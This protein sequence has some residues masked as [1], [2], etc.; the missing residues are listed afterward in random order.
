MVPPRQTDLHA[1]LRRGQGS[2]MCVIKVN[3]VDTEFLERL[4]D[5]LPGIGRRTVDYLPRRRTGTKLACQEYLAALS[6]ALE[7]VR[8]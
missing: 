2:P 6:C 8:A 4:V 5:G 3:V 7:P 1:A